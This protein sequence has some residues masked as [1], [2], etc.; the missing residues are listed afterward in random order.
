M[1]LGLSK[2]H[3]D[4]LVGDTDPYPYQNV[5][6]L[7]NLIRRYLYFIPAYVL[8]RQQLWGAGADRRLW[9]PSRR[10]RRSAAP[11]RPSS[12]RRTSSA[13]WTPCWGTPLLPPLPRVKKRPVEALLCKHRPC[14]ASYRHPR[15]RCFCPKNWS[16][17]RYIS[18]LY[19]RDRPARWHLPESVLMDRPK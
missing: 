11:P 9:P 15:R 8:S 1:F 6:D 13:I 2:P 17:F 4:P 7:F 16:R 5:T 10:P 12:Q 19:Q 18:H 3:P 14:Q